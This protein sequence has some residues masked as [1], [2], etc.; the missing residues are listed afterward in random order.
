[1]VESLGCICGIYGSRDDGESTAEHVESELDCLRKV[2]A[3]ILTIP[4]ELRMV[5]HEQAFG[6]HW[7]N[8][9]RHVFD[10]PSD[11]SDPF[12][13]MRFNNNISFQRSQNGEKYLPDPSEFFG[14][15]APGIKT[16]RLFRNE[17]LPEYKKFLDTKRDMGPNWMGILRSLRQRARRHEKCSKDC[18]FNERSEPISVMSRPGV[19]GKPRK[20]WSA[21]EVESAR[22][23]LETLRKVHNYAAEMEKG[24]G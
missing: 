12:T 15:E 2:D 16:C 17:G 21:V 9:E 10:E 13:P 18:T 19:Y 24:E 22:F 8:H 1:M 5:I 23:E 3:T 7:T 20:G 14:L 6:M 4:P 11:P